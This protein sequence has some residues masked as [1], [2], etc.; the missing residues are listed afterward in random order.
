MEDFKNK[1]NLQNI[2]CKTV[3]ES[4][5]NSF[6]CKNILSRRFKKSDTLTFIFTSNVYKEVLKELLAHRYMLMGFRVS[7][8]ARINNH[9]TLQFLRKLLNVVLINILFV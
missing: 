7:Y 4:P 2:R 6:Y 9:R 1:I 5:V 8:T 3:L